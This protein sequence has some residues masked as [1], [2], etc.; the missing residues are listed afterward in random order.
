MVSLNATQTNPPSWGLDRIDQRNRPLNQS[1][2]YPNTASNVRAYIIDTGIRFAH[3][4]FG[5][6][7]TSGYDAIDGGTA[8]DCNG[9]GTHVA[10]TV[11]GSTYGV[12]K[13]VRLVGVRVLNCAGSGTNVRCHRRR[14]LGD[15]ERGASRRW[16]T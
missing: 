9:H 6:R 7:A 2:T 11:G 8:D 3:T 15:R 13:A 14:Q 4:N 16:P 1:Y 10:G 12:A 5:G